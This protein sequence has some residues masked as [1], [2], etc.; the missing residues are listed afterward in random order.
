M[1]YAG[2]ESGHNLQFSGDDNQIMMS[3]KNQQ[4]PPFFD[5]DQAMVEIRNV[6]NGRSIIA[7]SI[8]ACSTMANKFSFD[9]NSYLLSSG[10]NIGN[11]DEEADG[12]VDDDTV[13]IHDF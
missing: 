9:L 8:R 13:I 12:A 6:I 2:L 11:G 4:R 5:N 1:I 7:P 10:V 3:S